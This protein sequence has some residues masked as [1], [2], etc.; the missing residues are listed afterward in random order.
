MDEITNAICYHFGIKYSKQLNEYQIKCPYH[1]DGNEQHKSASINFRKKLFNCFTCNIGKTFQQLYDENI[2]TNTLFDSDSIDYVVSNAGISQNKMTN[3]TL[4]INKILTSDKP[5]GDFSTT[6][7]NLL[8]QQT[9]IQRIQQE[10]PLEVATNF[11]IQSMKDKG[12]PLE[13]LDKIK[14]EPILISTQNYYGYIKFPTDN[15]NSFIYR[16]YLPDDILQGERY[17]LSIGSRPI[18]GDI[19]DK[20]EDY[21]LVEGYLDYL[22]LRYVLGYD[23]ALCNLSTAL[24]KERAYKLKGKV[25]FIL[26]DNDFAGFEATQKAYQILRQVGAFPIALDLPEKFGKDP[27]DAVNLYKEQFQEWLNFYIKQSSATDTEYIAQFGKEQILY[28]LKSGIQIIDNDLF[29]GGFGIGLHA[30]AAKPSVGKTA[31]GLY[32]SQSIV[33][34]NKDSKVLYITYEVPKKQCWARLSSIYDNEHTWPEI[35]KNSIMTDVARGIS[36]KLAD[37]IRIV[38][39]WDIS[40]IYRAANNYNAIV[41]DYIQV[42]PGDHLDEKVNVSKNIKALARLMMEKEK[43]IFVISTIPRSS[44]DKEDVSVFKESGDI[45]YAIQSGFLLSP[46]SQASDTRLIKCTVLKNTR[47]PVGGNFWFEYN[48]THNI[49]KEIIP[50]L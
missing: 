50:E 36:I 39:G 27:N 44:Y 37:K 17:L 35:E 30:F 31:L 42:M 11:A 41:I 15:N 38:Y 43:V 21:I 29:Q 22:S 25:V 23:N 26:F 24:N 32:L 19:C 16:K 48:T 46:I 40:E 13:L 9:Q 49:F 8:S 47:G 1:G 20:Y 34:N 10:I 4:D 3:I 2:R 18:V 5:I 33:L 28:T 45:E 7:S 12:I 6:L 14:A